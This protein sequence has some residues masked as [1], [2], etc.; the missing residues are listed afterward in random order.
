MIYRSTFLSPRSSCSTPSQYLGTKSEV[1]KV[2][3]CAQDTL[4]KKKKSTVSS[5]ERINVVLHTS[6]G[7]LYLAVRSLCSH[8]APS[9]KQTSDTGASCTG[10]GTSNGTTRQ[11]LTWQRLCVCPFDDKNSR[12]LGVRK[13]P[14]ASL[15]VLPFSASKVSRRHSVEGAGLTL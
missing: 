2:G 7:W 9:P 12:R 15:R 14:L 1:L 8:S 10:P 11:Y 5:R 6:E 4:L 13:D 3:R